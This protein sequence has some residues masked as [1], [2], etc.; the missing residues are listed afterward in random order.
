MAA[1]E[2]AKKESA[3]TTFIVQ[4]SGRFSNASKEELFAMVAGALDTA[5]A[6]G[7]AEADVEKYTEGFRAGMEEANII[8]ANM[9]TP[10][11]TA[12]CSI[13]LNHADRKIKT[14]I[15]QLPAKGQT[16]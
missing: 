16:P 15:S 8:V 3:K 14:A 2:W 5:R 4:R 7:K 12:S 6:A 11:L 10:L 13:I 1:S 9:K